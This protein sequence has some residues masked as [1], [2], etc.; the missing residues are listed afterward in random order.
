MAVGVINSSSTGGTNSGSLFKILDCKTLPESEE[1][2]DTGTKR[3]QQV[4]DTDQRSPNYLS[5]KTKGQIMY[6]RPTR[7]EEPQIQSVVAG[8][9]PNIE[10]LN[11][12]AGHVIYC[13]DEVY[14]LCLL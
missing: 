5:V 13:I 1:G 11:K 2:V 14:N 8:Q 4:Q 3:P 6:S 9:F 10:L 12:T 7:T